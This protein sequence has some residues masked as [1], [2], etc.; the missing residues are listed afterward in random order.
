LQAGLVEYNDEIIEVDFF[1]KMWVL[2]GN[3]LKDWY[4][5]RSGKKISSLFDRAFPKNGEREAY[6]Q[7]ISKI[8][9]RKKTDW[10]HENEVRLTVDDN[11]HIHSNS[12]FRTLTYDF[13]SLKG[14]VFGINT[15]A[16]DKTKIYDIIVR[17]CNENN[18]SEFRF[19]QA[20]YDNS[21]KSLVYDL[22]NIPS[23]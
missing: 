10:L 9:Y 2:N 4:T 15:T 1:K 8:K 3:Q 12:T 11:W 18:I 17:K 21:K 22:L 20:R 5:C 16:N 7:N 14:I 6:W 13:K 23:V 19:Y